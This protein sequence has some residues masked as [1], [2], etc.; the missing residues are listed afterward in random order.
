MLVERTFHCSRTACVTHVT[1]LREW[2]MTGVVTC[3]L[4]CGDLAWYCAWECVLHAAGAHAP[5]E[6]IEL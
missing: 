6:E 3:D 5:L 2:P 1:T 4:D